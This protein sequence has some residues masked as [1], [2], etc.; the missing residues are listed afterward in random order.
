MMPGPDTDM[1]VAINGYLELLTADHLTREQ[2]LQSLPPLLDTL[3]FIVHRIPVGAEALDQDPPE[4]PDSRYKDRY[5]QIERNFPD[6]GLYV[7]STVID[8]INEPMV[9]DAIDDLVDIAQDLEQIIWRWTHSGPDDAY[10]WFRWG[11]RFHWGQHLRDLSCHLHGR[12]APD[13]VLWAEMSPDDD[14]PAV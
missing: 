9:G 11:F 14:H 6:L 1:I 5:Q 2:R 10:W 12:L 4:I 13:Q 3:S 8:E 7:M